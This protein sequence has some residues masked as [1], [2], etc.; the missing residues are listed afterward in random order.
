M[1]LSIYIQRV[2]VNVTNYQ[3]IQNHVL[4]QVFNIEH[5]TDIPVANLHQCFCSNS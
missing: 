2:N 3:K 5:N 4:S 1:L